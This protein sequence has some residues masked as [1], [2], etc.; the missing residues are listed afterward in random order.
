MPYFIA[1]FLS[2]VFSMQLH[3]KSAQFDQAYLKWQAEQQAHDMRLKQQ[4]ST[5]NY[6]LSRPTQQTNSQ[7]ININT[8]SVSELQSLHG[9]GQKKAEAIV[10][11]RQQHGK[12]QSIQD[13][14]KVK[15]I[16]PKLFE[17]NQARIGL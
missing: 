8:A 13:L 2:I 15:G 17:K 11:Y 9:V 14:Q 10:E 16:G 4:N 12:F 7:K 6:Y 5:E 1:I 3:S